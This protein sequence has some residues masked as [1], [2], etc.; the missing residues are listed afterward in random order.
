MFYQQQLSD[1]QLRHFGGSLAAVLLAF[2]AMAHWKWQSSITAG[3][4]AAVAVGLA[5]VHYAAPASRRPIYNGFRRLTYPIQLVMTI[6]ILGI[7]YFGI[8]TPIGLLLRLRG[9]T[10]R[11]KGD[12]TKSLWAARKES[13]EPSSYFNT[14]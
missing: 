10:I 4:L 7:V 8:L 5:T 11:S 2:A 3:L 1:R 14:Y 12:S 6:I 13:G 9:V